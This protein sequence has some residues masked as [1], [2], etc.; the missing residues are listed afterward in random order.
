MIKNN[1]KFS[2]WQLFISLTLIAL[3]LAIS[4]CKFTKLNT[5]QIDGI[6][7]TQIYNKISFLELFEKKTI[8]TYLNSNLTI[9]YKKNH[10]DFNAFYDS[11]V[12]LEYFINGIYERSPTPYPGAVSQK[13][14]CPDEYLPHIS[15]INKTNEKLL[16]FVVG[17]GNERSAIGACDQTLAQTTILKISLYC[18]KQMQLFELNLSLKNPQIPYE[19]MYELA[20]QFECNEN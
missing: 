7:N 5:L 17:R 15:R 16:F 3:S 11:K 18:I 9:E 20:N 13:Q 14:N 12:R 19:K 8:H 2:T 1:H 10:G 6:S 4:S